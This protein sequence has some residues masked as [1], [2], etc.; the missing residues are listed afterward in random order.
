MTPEAFSANR[1]NLI[2]PGGAT[3]GKRRVMGIAPEQIHQRIPFAVGSTDAI[4][5][6]EKA[7]REYD[8]E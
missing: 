8:S 1:L 2:N 4:A 3:T 7:C 5:E 6:Y